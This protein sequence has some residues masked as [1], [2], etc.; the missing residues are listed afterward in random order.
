MKVRN[1]FG[2]R[3][4]GTLGKELVASSWKGHEYLR[5]YVVPRDPKTERQLQHREIWREAVAAW[6]ALSADDRKAY[7]RE[8][9]GMTGFNVFIGQY[10]RRRERGQSPPPKPTE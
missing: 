4:R 3:F 2:N 6:H 10:V 7:N 1:T 9:K 8:A 5:A